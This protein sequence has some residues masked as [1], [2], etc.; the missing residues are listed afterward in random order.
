MSKK[1]AVKAKLAKRHR[2]NQAQDDN[3]EFEFERSPALE[4]YI[5]DLMEI[6]R[7]ISDLQTIEAFLRI[8]I[9]QMEQNEEW[10]LKA[11]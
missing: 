10:Q 11:K 2:M 1:P 7:Q 3:L 8:R 9:Q 4:A 5:D 6:C